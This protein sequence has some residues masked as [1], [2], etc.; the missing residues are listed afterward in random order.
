MVRTN[1]KKYNKSHKIKTR[2]KTR[3]RPSKRPSKT[4]RNNRFLGGTEKYIDHNTITVEFDESALDFDK[5]GNRFPGLKDEDRG[6]VRRL[7]FNH[8]I[9]KNKKTFKKFE[10][11]EAE[12][13][14]DIAN[15]TKD[16]YSF[17]PDTTTNKTKEQFILE[18]ITKYKDFLIGE[19]ETSYNALIKTIEATTTGTTNANATTNATATTNANATN[20]S[21]ATATNAAN[22]L[23]TKLIDKAKHTIQN[24][25]TSIDRL[26]NISK[27]SITNLPGTQQ[28]DLITEFDKLIKQIKENQGIFNQISKLFEYKLLYLKSGFYNIDEQIAKIILD[29]T[30]RDKKLKDPTYTSNI[31]N[32]HIDTFE[33]KKEI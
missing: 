18:F 13:N 16:I 17:I 9:F 20:A 31:P 12:M 15:Y 7:K 32:T 14:A 29:K 2:N 21:T 23:I 8:A 3:K 25:G 6:I 19:N 1:R 30:I 24:L 27:S 11:T 4:K 33:I 26:Q 10:N 28:S 5:D 22:A